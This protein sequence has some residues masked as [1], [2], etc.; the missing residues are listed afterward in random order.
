MSQR[1]LEDPIGLDSLLELYCIREGELETTINTR[2]CSMYQSINRWLG[3][4]GPFIQPLTP[5]IPPPPPTV[6]TST[7]A[8]ASSTAMTVY[9]TSIPTMTAAVVQGVPSTTTT[10]H[11]M[12]PI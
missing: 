6:I 2:G 3:S 5:P 11:S 10:I 9:S 7:A 4:L 12:V 8:A 1:L